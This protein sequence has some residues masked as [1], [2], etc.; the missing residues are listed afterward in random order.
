MRGPFRFFLTA[1]LGLGLAACRPVEEET[2][3]YGAAATSGTSAAPASTS[4]ST[5]SA[6]A[7]PAHAGPTWPS[8]GPTWPSIGPTWR[9]KLELAAWLPYWD[10]AR[11]LASL[12]A[13]YGSAREISPFWY[14]AQADGTIKG[15]TGAGDAALIAELHQNGI[16]VLPTIRAEFSLNL[17]TGANPVDDPV[18][19]AKLVTELA[20]LAQRIDAD[21]LD[22]DFEGMT[23]NQRA[24]FSALARDL[25]AVLR[26]DRRLLSVTVVSK[27]SSPGKWSGQRSHDYLELGKA[28][29]RLRVMAYDEHWSGGAPGPVA[30]IP[31]VT[32]VLDFAVTRVARD[33]L[34][35]GVPFYGYDWSSAGGRAKGVVYEEAL[36]LAAQMGQT[37]VYD[38]TQGEA[39]F[40]YSASGA[41]HTVWFSTPKSQAERAKLASA[42][43]LRGVCAWRLGGEPAAYW[44]SI[45]NP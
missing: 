31:F 17:S 15:D 12:R 38:A 2:R 8:I 25:G 6:S 32:Q 10:K 37:P 29:D 33:K 43:G 39:H 4:A 41:T 1:L 34:V 7:A 44:D 14:R 16:L 11:G 35:L 3:V 30:S 28:A 22:L 36:A 24:G 9:S 13:L 26:A 45:K 42:R 27:T 20:A 21:G 18:R 40:Q 5:P 19:R 23:E